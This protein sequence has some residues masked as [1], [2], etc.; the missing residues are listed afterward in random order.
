MFHSNSLFILHSI[1]VCF[2]TN[3]FA[4]QGTFPL[5]PT[6]AVNPFHRNHKMRKFSI[7]KIALMPQMNV[8]MSLSRNRNRSRK[9]YA[10]KI[11]PFKSSY[12]TLRMHLK[13]KSRRSLQHYYAMQ[14]YPKVKKSLKR[15]FESN[16]MK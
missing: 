7:W 1:Y 14:K 6:L 15:N 9:L 3:A 13:L 12:K 2:P 5:H 10:N 16:G 8:S 4:P 11:Q